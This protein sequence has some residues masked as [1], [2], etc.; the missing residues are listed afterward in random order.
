MNNA[1]IRLSASEKMNLMGNLATML[2][3]GI[4]IME[5]VDSVAED[6]KGNLKRVLDTLKSDLVQGKR[7]YVSFSSFTGVFDKVTINLLK[8]AEEAGT[9]E[10][11]LKD[12]REHYQKQIEFSDKIKFAMIYPVF[13]MLVFAGVLLMILTFVVPKISTVFLRL[14]VDLP[15]STRI[16]MFASDL[17][18]KHTLQVAL[19]VGGGGT[20]IGFLYLKFKQQ[21]NNVFFKLPGITTLVKQI[22]L[23][24][25]TRSMFLLLSSGIPITT[26]L[27]LS[28][29]VVVR[30]QMANLI[31][32]SKEMV[33]SGHKLSEGLRNNKNDIPT[34]M[35]K[36]IE[37]GEKSGSLDKSMQE[38]SNF[39][40][41]QVSNTLK[42][43]TAVLEPIMLL[44]VGVAVGMMMISIIAPIYG[45]IGKVTVR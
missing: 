13:I 5:A 43:L 11:V 16:L 14:K 4:P 38:I 6:T 33:A 7:V 27:E 17:L 19:V 37:A 23:T 9:L 25:F 31:K 12:L 36:L 42:T 29:E 8:A 35:L 32:K 34:I 3:S 18:V 40:D 28:Q 30:S 15:L 45:L 2:S 22:D 20:L 1:K 44:F 21:V 41:Y 39:L 24:Q 26:A 10:T